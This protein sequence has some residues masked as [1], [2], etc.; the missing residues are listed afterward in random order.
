MCVSNVK[1]AGAV[2]KIG[3][4]LKLNHHTQIWLGQIGETHCSCAES[5]N[6]VY[7]NELMIENKC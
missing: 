1:A 6:I 3:S 5:Q 4:S 2:T 7:Q